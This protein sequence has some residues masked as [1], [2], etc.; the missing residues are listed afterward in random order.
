MRHPLSSQGFQQGSVLVL[1]REKRER[2]ITGR[3]LSCCILTCAGFAP[4]GVLVVGGGL[5]ARS[6]LASSVDGTGTDHDPH[7]LP[8]LCRMEGRR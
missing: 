1:K 3:Q 6:L 4:G 8:A 5:L 2:A 7:P